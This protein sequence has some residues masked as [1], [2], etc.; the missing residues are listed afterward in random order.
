MKIQDLLAE[1]PLDI[2]CNN[3]WQ[4]LSGQDKKYLR[5]VSSGVRKQVDALV[6]S[7]LLDT[8]DSCTKETLCDASKL[9]ALKELSIE[10]APFHGRTLT[11]ALRSAQLSSLTEFSLESQDVKSLVSIVKA[12]PAVAASL[13]SITLS[14]MVIAD[15]VIH[16]VPGC[17][18]LTE[19]TLREAYLGLSA[20]RSLQ[21]LSALP[22]LHTLRI[23]NCR[24]LRVGAYTL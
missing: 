2:L 1:I 4:D 15:A 10:A 9:F 13:R 14:G 5:L 7:F 22:Q 20:Q 6:E 17:L 16:A 8:V 24:L 3:I 19:L 23:I 18:Q 12:L 11:A 21:A